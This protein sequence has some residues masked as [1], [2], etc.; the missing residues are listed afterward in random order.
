M[1]SNMQQNQLILSNLTE[2][3]KHQLNS[4]SKQLHDLKMPELPPKSAFDY[5]RSL[6]L[7]SEPSP[8]EM[9]LVDEKVSLVYSEY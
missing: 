8:A 1:K 9:H 5:F 6:G 7:T 4:I 2:L 3:E